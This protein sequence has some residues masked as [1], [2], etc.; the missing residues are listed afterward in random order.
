MTGALRDAEL[1]ARQV[2]AAHGGGVADDVALA[3]YQRTR[4]RLSRDLVATTERV[5]AHDWDAT[6]LR[7]LLHRLS[8]AMADEVEHLEALAPSGAAP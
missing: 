6:G 4:D 7:S 1:L 2:L 3:D 5:A 8:A